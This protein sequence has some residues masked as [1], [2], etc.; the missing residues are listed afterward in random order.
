M[1]NIIFDVLFLGLVNSCSNKPSQK[2][3]QAD[4]FVLHQHYR[5]V[6]AR[7]AAEAKARFL[8]IDPKTQEDLSTIDLM[9]GHEFEHYVAEI[10]R[11]NGYSNVKVTSGSG[12][13]G[14]DILAEN[15]ADKYAIQIKRQNNPVSRRAVSDAVSGALHHKCNKAM[16]ITNNSMSKSG[17]KFSESTNCKVIQRDELLELIINAN[18]LHKI[19]QP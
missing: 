2:Q 19:N 17:L 16:V 14:V 1:L 7:K 11:S 15:G 5:E 12:D 10:L 4:A 8:S 18:K 6:S 3:K 13:F 9:G